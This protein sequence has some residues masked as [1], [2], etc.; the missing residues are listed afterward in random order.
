MDGIEK[1]IERI[2]AASAEECAVIAQ[3][4]EKDCEAIRADYAHKVP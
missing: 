1:I 3:E 2:N 4:A